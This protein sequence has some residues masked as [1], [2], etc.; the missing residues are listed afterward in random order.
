MSVSFC[1]NTGRC[2]LVEVSFE[3]QQEEHKFLPVPRIFKIALR[4]RDGHICFLV[5]RTTTENT[6]FPYKSAK[7]QR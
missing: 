1:L 7:S 4:L 5:E 6:I 2:L 3:S